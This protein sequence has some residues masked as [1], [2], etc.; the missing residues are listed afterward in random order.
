MKN[1]T[2]LDARPG[3]RPSSAG[4]RRRARMV[5]EPPSLDE[6]D[7]RVAAA[8]GRPQPWLTPE[9]L[10]AAYGVPVVVG[11]KVYRKP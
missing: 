11:P 7:K 1:S 3:S 9:G 2:G 4:S 10:E 8:R 5:A 6:A